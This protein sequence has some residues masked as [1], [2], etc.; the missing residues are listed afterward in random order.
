[1]D[2]SI[3][4]PIYNEEANLALLVEQ[5]LAAV[6]PLGRS[7][8]IVLEDDGSQLPAYTDRANPLRTVM[9]TAFSQGEASAPLADG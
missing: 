3:V 1:M 7:F 6:R 9:K 5:L 4:V 2:L 8:E